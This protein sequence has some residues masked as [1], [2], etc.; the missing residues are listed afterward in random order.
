V[1]TVTRDHAALEGLTFVGLFVSRCLV[2][3][4]GEYAM[5]EERANEQLAQNEE[6]EESSQLNACVHPIEM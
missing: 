5:V 6:S 2:G 1:L 3:R 4:D